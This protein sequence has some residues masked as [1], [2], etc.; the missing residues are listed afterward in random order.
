MAVLTVSKVRNKRLPP[1]GL[2]T[3]EMQMAGIT[4]TIYKGSIVISDT[5]ANDG[6]VR[7]LTT[8]TADA[9]DI[10]VGIAIEEKSILSSESDGDRVVTVAI[11]GHWGFAVGSLAITDLGAPAYASDDDTITTTSSNNQWVGFIVD[12]YADFIW[13]DISQAVFRTNAAT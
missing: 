9:A 7:A 1:S 8:G 5:S 4:E 10:F 13:V 11:N 12:R 3:A 6:Y 2:F